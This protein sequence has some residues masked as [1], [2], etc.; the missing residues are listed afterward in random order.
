MRQFESGL[1]P[2]EQRQDMRRRQRYFLDS[3]T[4]GV[5]HGARNRR[6]D[7]ENGNFAGAL[8]AQ[9]SDRRRAFIEADLHGHDVLRQ[10]RSVGLEACLVYSAIRADRNLLMQGVSQSLH[11]AAL[12]L[13]MDGAR[14][15]R[16]ADILDDDVTQHFDVTRLGIHRDFAF[17]NGEDGNINGF[18]EMAGRATRHRRDARSGE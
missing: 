15:Q 18:D 1:V 4:G 2:Q 16:S 6:R 3:S 5:G 12:Y 8:G 17:V 7:V 11:D 10:R 9:G 13:A 14:V